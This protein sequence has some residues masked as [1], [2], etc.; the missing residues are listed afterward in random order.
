[1]AR[2][3]QQQRN[4]GGFIPSNQLPLTK[5]QLGAVLEYTG[6]N[7]LWLNKYL[8][9]WAQIDG[10]L[11]NVEAGLTK[12]K[13]N[14]LKRIVQLVSAAITKSPPST[15]NVTVYKG[16]ED[17][18][19]EWLTVPVGRILPH[20]E[21]GIVSTS[22]DKNMAK[23]FMSPAAED[24]SVLLTLAL[25]KGTKGLFVQSVSQFEDE[26][27]VILPHGTRFR[28]TK[29]TFVVYRGR[30]CVNYICRLSSQPK[31]IARIAPPGKFVTT[32]T[33]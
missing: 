20:T 24:R 26:N 19:D 2:R 16:I 18:P 15:R 9:R 10:G 11:E 31:E 4:Y 22:F 14:K 23:T 17:V 21:R 7:S 8:D 28:V 12:T 3:Q 1:M 5:T 30:R 6:G 33:T 25:P 32:A 13:Q 27:E 29:R